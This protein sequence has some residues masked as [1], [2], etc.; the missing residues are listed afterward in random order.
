VTQA[1]AL[2]QQLLHQAP[3]HPHQHLLLLLLLAVLLAQG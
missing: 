2:Q 3:Y 1:A